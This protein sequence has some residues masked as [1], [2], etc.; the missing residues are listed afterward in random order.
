MIKKAILF[1]SILLINSLIVQSQSDQIVNWEYKYNKIDNETYELICVAKISNLWHLFG[2]YFPEGG[3]VRLKV[4]FD[5]SNAFEL[6][7]KTSE[8]PSPKVIYDDIF[9]INIQY[10]TDE[11]TFTQKI[12]LIKPTNIKMFIEGQIR[13]RMTKMTRIISSEYVFKL[14]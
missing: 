10:F 13:N 2:Q 5:E 14:E 1:F 4:L 12:K 8:S 7:G 6:I 3:P 11:V 9:D